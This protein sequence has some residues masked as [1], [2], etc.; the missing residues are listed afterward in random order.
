MKLNT[1]ILL[2]AYCLLVVAV[3]NLA[4]G[5]K[6]FGGAGIDSQAAGIQA[7]VVFPK[8]P[9]INTPFLGF[10]LFPSRSSVSSNNTNQDSF[11]SSFGQGLS[12]LLPNISSLIPEFDIPENSSFT[13]PSIT[14]PPSL[15]SLPNIPGLADAISEARNHVQ[16]AINATSNFTEGIDTALR[17]ALESNNPTG[18]VRTLVNTILNAYLTVAQN[19]PMIV[20]GVRVLQEGIRLAIEVAKS[21]RNIV[22][23]SS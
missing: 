4:S 2:S 16:I 3:D 11:S 18:A 5:A 21:A 10:S 17:Q 20:V 15:G 8:I 7:G 23:G 22:F 12:S 9:G 19:C 1:Y 13:V 6:I 14:G